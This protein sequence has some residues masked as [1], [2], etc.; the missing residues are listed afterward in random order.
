MRR[1]ILRSGI[2]VVL[3]SSRDTTIVF[4]VYLEGDIVV[5]LER[6]RKNNKYT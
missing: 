3:F 5:Y 2:E 1:G 6:L 4:G